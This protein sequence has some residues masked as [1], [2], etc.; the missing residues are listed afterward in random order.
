MEL[1]AEGT[2]LAGEGPQLFD[3]R[4]RQWAAQVEVEARLLLYP[5]EFGLHLGEIR[6]DAVHG[7]YPLWSIK[8]FH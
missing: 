8:P 4:R 3:L 6:S 7:I 2:A 1:N 5:L